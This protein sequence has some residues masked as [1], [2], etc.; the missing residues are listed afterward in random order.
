[1]H[2][3]Y[4]KNYKFGSRAV[5]SLKRTSQV[6]RAPGYKRGAARRPYPTAHKGMKCLSRALSRFDPAL[7]GSNINK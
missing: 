4:N 1:M 5:L 6:P 3:L 7:S 2:K